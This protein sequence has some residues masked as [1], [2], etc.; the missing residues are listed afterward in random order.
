MQLGPSQ[1]P[2]QELLPYRKVK[3]LCVYKGRVRSLH[4]CR[5]H[6][7]YDVKYAHQK[8]YN[9]KPDVHI[10]P[11][12]FLIT[13]HSSYIDYDGASWQYVFWSCRTKWKENVS[14]STKAGHSEFLLLCVSCDVIFTSDQSLCVKGLCSTLCEMKPGIS[15]CTSL[16][17]L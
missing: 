4:T 5:Q 13:I 14:I 9:I 15:I 17:S 2:F 16:I 11:A 6:W 12:N 3:L 1:R 10:A 8:L 7:L